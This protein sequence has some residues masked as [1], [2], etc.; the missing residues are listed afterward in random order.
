MPAFPSVPARFSPEGFGFPSTTLPFRT[1][2]FWLAYCPCAGSFRTGPRCCPAFPSDGIH[3]EFIL[4]QYMRYRATFACGADRIQLTIQKRDDLLRVTH[5]DI[6]RC[7][8]EGDALSV[9]LHIAGGVEYQQC[10]SLFCNVHLK[11]LCA[12]NR[13]VCFLLLFCFGRSPRQHNGIPCFSDFG[14]FPTA[15][16]LT[17]PKKIFKPT[18]PRFQ[19]LIKCKA[20]LEH[21]GGCQISPSAKSH[22]PL[23][24]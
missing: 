5:R 3:R 20:N 17:F 14:C 19:K 8:D 22:P 7:A 4:R 10:Q 6:Q 18:P 23:S 24:S 1:S 2:L 21:I 12:I 16:F 15:H 13:Y 11:I 9:E